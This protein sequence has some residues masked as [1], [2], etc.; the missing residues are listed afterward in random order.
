MGTGPT[1]S[2]EI[3][4][5]SKAEAFY[6]EKK[7]YLLDEDID[8]AEVVRVLEEDGRHQL[9]TWI[10]SGLIYPPTEREVLD[11]RSRPELQ[12]KFCQAT[13][14]LFFQKVIKA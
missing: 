14:Y 4:N 9:D 3:G 2:F 1:S 7:L 8:F 5:W 6:N 13:P 12:F 10:G 11:F